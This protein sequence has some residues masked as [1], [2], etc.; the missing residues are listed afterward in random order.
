MDKEPFLSN[1]PQGTAFLYMLLFSEHS[2]GDQRLCPCF[3]Q[4]VCY[5][6]IEEIFPYEILSHCFSSVFPQNQTCIAYFSVILRSH[7]ASF[8]WLY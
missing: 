4:A 2:N 8:L 7:H 1:C 5:K 6:R 3:G